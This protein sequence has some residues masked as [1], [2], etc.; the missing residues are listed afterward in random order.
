MA[1]VSFLHLP[2]FDHDLFLEEI[3]TVDSFS[4]WPHDRM[5]GPTCDFDLADDMG[6]ENDVVSLSERENQVNFVMNMLHQ[7]VDESNLINAV[8]T[9]A[10]ESNIG[11][12]DEG[13]DL[14]PHDLELELGLGLGSEFGNN[15][16]D[17]NTN[18]RDS[19]VH[20]DDDHFCGF[21]ITDCGDDFYIARRENGSRDFDGSSSRVSGLRAVWGDSDSDGEVDRIDNILSGIHV[22][23]DFEE[24]FRVEN[25]NDDDDDDLSVPVCWDLEEEENHG[26]V[27]VNHDFDWEE[28]GNGVDE[29]EVLSLGADHEDEDGGISV[30]NFSG[31]EEDGD[32]GRRMSNLEWEVLLNVNSNLDRNIEIE[33]EAEPYFGDHDDFIDTAEYEMMFGQFMDG[34]S[35]ILG[36]PPASKA[37]VENLPSV[38]ISKEDVTDEKSL[39]A[40]CKE[41]IEVGEEGKQLP[42]SHLY[43][44]DCIIPWLQ[45]RNTCP[46]CRFELPTDDPDY[47]Q[48]RTRR[49]AHFI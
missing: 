19:R 37:V 24:D 13:I 46:V 5:M 29:R 1:E 7:R 41:M 30:L 32:R 34:E 31:P 40:V 45:I 25:V 39:C 28:V 27:L 16:D 10:N 15:Y 21:A 47:E 35:A 20:D 42:C 14:G 38:V 8:E 18:N 22:H 26:D 3:S 44:G 23:S 48:R 11:V 36:R 12:I 43:H 4:F 33:D 17:H 49:S 6:N 2:E 9:E